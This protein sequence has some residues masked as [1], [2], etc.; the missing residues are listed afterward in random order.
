MTDILQHYQKLMADAGITPN[1]QDDNDSNGYQLMDAL[2]KVTTG[3]AWSNTGITYE[4]ISAVTWADA[5]APNYGATYLRYNNVVHLSG[6]VEG[7]IEPGDIP[8]ITLPVDMRPTSEVRI[9][10]MYIKTGGTRVLSYIT[11]NTVGQVS[12]ASAET[13]NDIF[14][15][16]D[17]ISFRKG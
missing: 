10:S 15:S 11:I 2:L 9:P 14:V 3:G 4:T 7:R 1:E 17:G 13:S 8:M 12:I 16:L 5:G 6:C